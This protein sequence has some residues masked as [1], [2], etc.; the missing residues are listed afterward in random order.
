[1][2][3]LGMI[4]CYKCDGP[5]CPEIAH[6]AI[7]SSFDESTLMAGLATLISGLDAL[8]WTMASEQTWCPRHWPSGPGKRADAPSPEVKESLN[9]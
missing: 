7:D 9:D 8:G 2:T 1:M 3:Y 5:K 6:I 4:A